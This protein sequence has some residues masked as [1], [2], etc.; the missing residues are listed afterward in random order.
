MILSE[1][2]FSAVSWLSDWRSLS[3]TAV[4]LVTMNVWDAHK[5]YS[6]DA[7]QWVDAI[8][9]PG[10]LIGGLVYFE[11]FQSQY[12]TNAVQSARD[13]QVALISALPHEDPD[14]QIETAVL[15]S[16]IDNYF[17]E[18][19]TNLEIGC[20]NGHRFEC[21]FLT[22]LPEVLRA[23]GEV[24]VYNAPYSSDLD[25]AVFFSHPTDGYT[26]EEI[27][28]GY[29]RMANNYHSLAR[30]MAYQEDKR[31]DTLVSLELLQPAYEARGYQF[32]DDYLSNKARHVSITEAIEG[33][34]AASTTDVTNKTQNNWL[35]LMS[36]VLLLFAKYL[37]VFVLAAKIGKTYASVRESQLKKQQ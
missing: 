29:E 24:V 25:Q 11:L 1:W 3:M 20:D 34:I 18:L 21:E 28:R 12:Q 35:T 10:I 8:Y 4:F 15:V 19:V 23:D 31:F 17:E 27:C 7:W 33:V 6:K 16:D 30:R 22:R 26:H 13:T 37:T 5:R 36:G 14:S 9:Y 2:V 32:C